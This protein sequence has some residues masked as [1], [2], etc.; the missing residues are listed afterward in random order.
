MRF[1][2][3]DSI[4]SIV[5][6]PPYGIEFMGKEWDKFKA[7]KDTG[8]KYPGQTKTWTSDAGSGIGVG[9]P[10]FST[11]TT[12][13]LRLFQA[14]C[15]QWAREAYRVLKP[16]GYLLAFGG[17]RTVHR[18]TCGLEDAGFEVRDQLEWI[19]FSGFP[20]SLNLTGGIGTALKPGHEPVVMA[21]KPLIGTVK[22]NVLRYGT[23]GI[24]IDGCRIGEDHLTQ[25]GRSDGPNVAMS[26]RNYAEEPGRTW[27]GRWPANVIL[28]DPVFDG[29]YPDEVVGGGTQKSGG[30]PK[31]RNVGVDGRTVYGEGWHGDETGQEPMD[32][33]VGKSRFFLIPKSSKRDR[34]TDINGNPITLPE[35]AKVFNGKSA[36][37][38]PSNSVHGPVNTKFS[39]QPQS[40]NH[41]T[42]KPTELMRHLVRLVTPPGGV[43]LDPFAGSGS[44]GVACFHEGV[45]FIGIEKD[46]DSVWIA[47]ARL[48]IED[49]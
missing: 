47:K 38:S 6:D 22:N 16:G 48:G 41:P 34:N 21:R 14:W 43:C 31:R 3:A 44:T 10:R 29:D 11:Q 49:A 42:V 15:E 36:N 19:Y 35:K 13:D 37:P 26:G 8:Q 25:H 24:N 1:L 12:K 9:G 5:C 4:D 40:N 32:T 28:T 30:A 17:T 27:S 20:K 18:L 45:D 7:V 2:P 46:K 23:G 39:T 33:F